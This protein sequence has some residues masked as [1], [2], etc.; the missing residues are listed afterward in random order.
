V[1]VCDEGDFGWAIDHCFGGK[2]GRLGSIVRKGDSID[3]PEMLIEFLEDLF[4][5]GD[6][7][8]REF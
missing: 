4:E 6:V 2:A 8:L 5:A 3:G 1:G 7:G